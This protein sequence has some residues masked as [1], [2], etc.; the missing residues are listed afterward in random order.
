MSKTFSPTKRLL[1]KGIIATC[2]LSVSR[3]GFAATKAQIVAVRVWP[4]STYTRITLESNI[5]LNY[6]RSALRNP[7]R[8]VIDIGKVDLNTT[9][10]SISSKVLNHD[11]YIKSIRVLQLDP[12]TV[13]IMI[14]LKQGVEPNTFT[15]PPIET[16][17]HRLVMDLYPSKSA[18]PEDNDPLLALLEEYTKGDLTQKQSQIKTTTNKNKNAPVVV[19]LDPGHGG[20]DPGAIGYKKT[21]EKDIVLQIARRTYNLLKKEPNIKVYM[22]RNE[23]VFIPLNVR[24]AKAR[25]LH[26]DLFISIHADAFT[27]RSVKGSTVFALS[28]KGASSSAASYL[29]QTQNKADQI[30]GVSR[31]GDKY[32]D[33]T[34]LDLVQKTTLSNGVLL[35]NAILNRMKVVN[36]LHKPSIEKAGFAVLKAPDIPSVL[37]ETAFISNIN[38]EKK[39]KTASFQNQ[40]SKAILNGIK[41]YLKKRKN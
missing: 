40:I 1:V 7:D 36:Q 11:P 32:L 10:K 29:A 23:D 8:M 3:V 24:V 9:L 34:I 4:S 2:L 5:K 16:F 39:L 12:K 17:K 41:D 38:E 6:K 20:E 14:V 25:S 26:A 15:L 28:T 31:S 30:G 37:V 21:R 22:T 27:N 33:N 13:R 19:V 35:G 18:S